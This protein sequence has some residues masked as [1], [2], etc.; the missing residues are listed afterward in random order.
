MI[1]AVFPETNYALMI[2]AVDCLASIRNLLSNSDSIS[3]CHYGIVSGF[4]NEEIIDRLLSRSGLYHPTFTRPFT[5]KYTYLHT[6]MEDLDD[7]KSDVDGETRKYASEAEL[8][9]QKQA[10][11]P[12]KMRYSNRRERRGSS[13]SATTTTSATTATTIATTI[14]TL[15]S[16]TTKDLSSETVKHRE[17]RHGVLALQEAL[18]QTTQ[19]RDAWRDE[20]L[21]YMEEVRGKEADTFKLNTL[22]AVNDYEKVQLGSQ[23]E[24]LTRH[25][26]SSLIYDNDN[27]ENQNNDLEERF[28]LHD[29][30]SKSG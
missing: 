2:S 19:Q 12:R 26:L 3:P 5:D 6:H 28:S 11:I 1:V 4:Q 24:E 30:G 17:A 21:A 16:T 29:Q 25:L 15:A 9:P 14:S 18:Q 20:A 10:N 23:R 27:L 8:S 13:T 7:E 22:L